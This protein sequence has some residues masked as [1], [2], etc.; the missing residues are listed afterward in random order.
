MEGSIEEPEKS[1]SEDEDKEYFVP[2]ES[3][4]I[5]QAFLLRR[6]NVILARG[7][8]FS[9]PISVSLLLHHGEG[10]VSDNFKT[11]GMWD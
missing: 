1:K 9:P 10:C 4:Y 2:T 7:N 8:R 11:H 6:L 5:R 3:V